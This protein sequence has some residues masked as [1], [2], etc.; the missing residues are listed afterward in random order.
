MYKRQEIASR[1]YSGGVYEEL[2]DA[3]TQ[4]PIGAVTQGGAVLPLGLGA[5][6]PA[7]PGADGALLALPPFKNAALLKQKLPALRILESERQSLLSDA[8]RLTEAAGLIDRRTASLMSSRAIPDRLTK[9]G[10]GV[11]GREIPKKGGLGQLRRRF[12]DA[13]TPDGYLRRYG[14]ITALANRIYDVQDSWG[15]A[16]PMLE[17]IAWDA[18]RKGY[19]VYACM[20]PIDPSRVLHVVIPQLSLAFVTSDGRAAFPHRPFRRI[21]ADGCCP[22]SSSRDA[23]SEARRLFRLSRQIM[24]GVW[25][26]LEEARRI[27]AKMAELYAPHADRAAL[28]YNLKQFISRL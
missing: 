4:K 9:R 12:A 21:R 22:T 6:A 24:D 7:F 16:A 25:P 14:S 26:L 2:R 11:S 15:L 28:E 13:L 5:E 18:V 8:A 23:R 3:V 17:D 10:R 20:C 1:I 27:E 19:E